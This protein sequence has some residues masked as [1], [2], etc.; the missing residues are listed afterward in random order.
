MKKKI[1]ITSFPF[2]EK[3]T[4]D[5]DYCTIIADAINN[6]AKINYEAE[7]IRA[8]NINNYNVE[9]AYRLFSDI[10]ENKGIGGKNFYDAL[11]TFY[12]NKERKQLVSTVIQYIKNRKSS[13]N[14]IVNIQLR[15][16]ET[17]FLFSPEDIGT[18]KE[19]GYKICITCH[20]Y[21]LNYHRKWLQ[22]IMHHYFFQSDLVLFFSEQDKKIATV[23]A[24]HSIFIE[25]ICDFLENLPNE[26][27]QKQL[28]ALQSRYSLSE[29]QYLCSENIISY[30][31]NREISSLKCDMFIG[32]IR[33]KKGE[34]R[35]KI[36]NIT[37]N[38]SP[39]IKSPLILEWGVRQNLDITSKGKFELT[40]IVFNP[41]GDDLAL[42]EAQN[43]QVL[44]FQYNCDKYDLSSKARVTRVPPTIPSSDDMNTNFDNKP[45]N[46]GIFGLIREGKG[47]K[48]ALKII[49]DIYH[50]ESEVKKLPDTRLVIVGKVSSYGLL[51]L[52]LNKKFAVNEIITN[53]DLQTIVNS[54]DEQ[55]EQNIQQLINKITREKKQ[56]IEE[57]IKTLGNYN[58]GLID[59]IFEGLQKHSNSVQLQQKS[60]LQHLVDSIDSNV[61]E[62]LPIDLYL[63]V[64][65]NELPLV[66]NQIKYAIKYDE[67]GWANNASALINL[68]THNTIL[69]TG[70]GMCTDEKEVIEQFENSIVF[71]G[72]QYGLKANEILSP[73]EEEIGKRTHFYAGSQKFNVKAKTSPITAQDVIEDI[74]QRESDPSLNELTLKTSTALLQN[75]SADLIASNLIAGFDQLY[76]EDNTPYADLL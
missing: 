19:A 32:E 7:Y 12:N 17:G 57:K 35:Y 15:A 54:D 52:I 28:L 13:E 33:F 18:L 71:L 11:E 26:E 31:V 62:K 10:Q 21:E 36:N 66:F 39:S 56:N 6:A 63:D 75:F 60:T 49:Q 65:K 22:S 2:S 24:N 64:N 16:P 68:L 67:K 23:H 73:L 9:S 14:D 74:L 29:N 61:P 70:W 50:E 72:G 27:Q 8:E 41:V 38:A 5:Y 34:V 42:D 53:D 69:Y 1:F 45:L 3:D 25:N 4:G 55:L 30:Y 47:F 51:A 76:I 48:Y 46:I 40:G 59:S 58:E 43:S 44:K 20:E 37:T